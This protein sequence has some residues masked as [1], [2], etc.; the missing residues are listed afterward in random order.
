MDLNSGVGKQVGSESDLGCT[1]TYT[2]TCTCIFDG[3]FSR[4]GRYD[5]GCE[6][7]VS[8]LPLGASHDVRRLHNFLASTAC[9]STESLRHACMCC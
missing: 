7:E 6:L 3:K 8:F 1:C 9:S 4:P 2:C 5:E